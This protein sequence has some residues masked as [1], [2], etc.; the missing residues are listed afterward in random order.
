MCEWAPFHFL[1]MLEALRR[2]SCVLPLGAQQIEG[3]LMLQ[4]VVAPEGETARARRT[5]AR[6]HEDRCSVLGVCICD[7]SPHS[8]FPGVTEPDALCRRLF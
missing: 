5:Q 1:L 3:P 8:T 7:S 2:R 6:S 4:A